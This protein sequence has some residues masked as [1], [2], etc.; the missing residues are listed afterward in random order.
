MG[1]EEGRSDPDALLVALCP[2]APVSLPPF[3]TREG[4]GTWRQDD[5]NM[6]Q[7]HETW[8]RLEREA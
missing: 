2:L 6:Q 3:G 4:R 5:N 1:R 8:N 7:Q